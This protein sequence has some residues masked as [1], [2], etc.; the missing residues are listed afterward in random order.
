MVSKSQ[1]TDRIS[2][3]NSSFRKRSTSTQYLSAIAD[4]ENSAEAVAGITNRQAVDPN[5]LPQ[6]ITTDPRIIAMRNFLIDYQSPMYPYADVFVTEADKVGLDWRLVAA[7]SGVESAFGNLIP[8]R[9]NNAWGWKGDPT[10]DWSYFTSWRQGITT[11][12][13][14]LAIGYGT[15]LTPFDIEATYCPPCGLNPAHAWANGVN[16]FMIELDSYTKDL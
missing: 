2:P 12:T 16:N 9:S 10:R 7:I 8:Y 6:I 11:V 15:D 14:R 4:R 5:D 1:T 3:D 13:Q